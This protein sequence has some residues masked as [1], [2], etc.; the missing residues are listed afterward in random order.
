MIVLFWRVL[1]GIAA[2]GLFSSSVFLLL[3]LIAS[4]RFKKRADAALHSVLKVSTLPRVSTTIVKTTSFVPV[5][6]SF[7]V[8][9][10]HTARC[11]I[12]FLESCC[13]L[14]CAAATIEQTNKSDG[15]VTFF[16]DSTLRRNSRKI[17]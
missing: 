11:A 16:M 14:C 8:A 5:S 1:L 9:A 10:S 6:R 3:V 12:P 2:F 15:R 17:P 4:T 7:G 13:P